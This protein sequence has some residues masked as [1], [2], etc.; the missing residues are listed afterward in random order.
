MNMSLW[1][2]AGRHNREN[3]KIQESCEYS[4]AG[5]LKGIQFFNK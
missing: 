3:Q 2:H 1:C 4:D 5:S